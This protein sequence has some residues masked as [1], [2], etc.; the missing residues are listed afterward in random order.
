MTIIYFLSQQMMYFAV[1]LLIVGLGGL[2]SEKSGVTNISLEGTMVIGGLSG[3]LFIN[4]FQGQLDGQL[5]L[6]I[7][8][9]IAGLSGAVI[10]LLHAFAA[11]NMHA[12]QIISGTA[13]NTFAPAFSIF[14]ARMIYGVQQIPFSNTFKI[15]Q[16]PVL[17]SIPIIG[18][19]L[20]Q[21]AYITTYLG[22][23]ILAITSIV[24][25]KTKFGLRMV[26]CG[27]YPQS[28][29]S[30]GVSVHKVRYMSVLISGFLSGLGG[31]IF[32]IPTSTSFNATVSG[33]G[34]LALAVLIFGQWKPSGVFFASL[35]FGIMKT[36]SATYSS[37]PIL[38]NLAISSEIYKM[39]PYL[40]TLIVL[41]F[42]AKKSK[43]PRSVGIPYD[44]GQR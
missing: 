20:F 37:I 12:D 30:V 14:V 32:I 2:F 44:K 6:L 36:I 23:L 42:T 29:D 9:L 15:S 40:A 19:I 27:E 8:L 26:A 24:V 18:P 13:I 31:L 25:Y 17:G 4:S 43:A 16:V 7:A 22:W 34:F 1:P 35:F 21:N 3:V 10:I 41:F 39:I 11:I 38:S 28:A 5:L 33:Y